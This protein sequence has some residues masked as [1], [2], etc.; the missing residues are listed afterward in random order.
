MFERR[1]RAA[2]ILMVLAALPLRQLASADKGEAAE[3]AT[4][5]VTGVT[6]PGAA[7]GTGE[8]DRLTGL[9]EDFDVVEID[10]IAIARDPWSVVSMA[11]G[12]V[13][14]RINVGGNEAGR[15]PQLTVRGDVAGRNTM[16]SIDGMTVTDMF[17]TGSSPAFW[18]IEAFSEIQV[19]T[20]GNDSSL[21]T[22]GMAI[23]LVTKRG[24]NTPRGS[25][26]FSTTSE[27]L[28][29][30]NTKKMASP[31]NPGGETTLDGFKWDPV[32]KL[33][34][35][36]GLRDYGIE[37]G[38]PIMKDRAWYWGAAGTQDI[39][40][41]FARNTQI[42]YPSPY[43]PQQRVQIDNLGLKMEATPTKDT[44]IAYLYMRSEK[45][46]R[47][48]GSRTWVRP[49]ETTWNESGP[50]NIHKADV[51]WTLG[52]NLFFEG[53]FGYV[54][55]GFHQAPVGGL[56]VQVRRDESAVYHG[57]FLDYRTQRPQWHV[58]TD[59]TYITNWWGGNHDLRFGFSFRRAD[60]ESISRWPGDR[61]IANA[62]YGIAQLTRDSHNHTRNDY[63]S[64][65]AEDVFTRGNLSISAG[66]RFDHQS[67]GLLP[68]TTPANPMRPD[69][70]PSVTVAAMDAPFS[71][72]DI[73]P[74]LGVTYD[75]SG[76]G[77]TLV[78]AGFSRYA[79]Q[80]DA[81][82]L[83]PL[84]PISEG[85]DELDY[86]WTD[87]NGDGQAQYEEI[88]FDYE[89]YE[90]YY[91]YPNDPPMTVLD[92]DL[93]APRRTEVIVGGEHEIAEG[94]VVGA[95]F[96]WRKANNLIWEVGTDYR[97]PDRLYTYDDYELAGSITG[98]LPDGTT[99][100]VPYYA[101]KPSRAYLLGAG[102]D[103]LV[104]NRHGYEEIYKGLDLRVTRRLHGDRLFLN[105]SVT[106]QK[107]RRYFNGT[108]GISNPTN[109]I[110][111]DNVAFQSTAV[112][113]IDYWVGT[114]RWQVGLSGYGR[115]PWGLS[116]G[117]NLSAREGFPIVY[118]EPKYYLDP[119]TYAT[120]VRATPMGEIVLPSAVNLDLRFSKFISLGGKGQINLDLDVFNVLNSNTPLHVHERVKRTNTNEVTDLMD[121]RL[122]RLGVRYSF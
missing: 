42:P 111:G 10:E 113:T 108:A 121:P 76:N 13:L 49:V 27:G 88:D 87:L 25:A 50:V 72:N 44:S 30:S 24:G 96:I 107:N 35:L 99:Y 51:T 3:V 82:I 100:D 37:I 97:R 57:S 48:S 52:P 89:V 80:L 106:L 63:V 58:K 65:H 41:E 105:A 68:A 84:S 15:Q 83:L 21:A 59:T 1:S 120:N 23:N 55:A 5:N 61:V 115:L 16:W 66:F 94:L 74:R 6:V 33:E 31:E 85:T 92:Q 11:H 64:F 2:L 73:S 20:G 45:A 77:K 86:L 103:S 67:G 70:L 104:T 14:D 22:G 47:G 36:T 93:R 122:V 110:D 39:R 62:Y 75:V 118:F 79:D 19:T 81:R 7:E 60:V 18:D 40:R 8:S 102:L 54:D 91:V 4:E 12:P 78:R 34:R 95:N 56:D 28:Q 9:R 53:T 112:G 101:L 32:L 29:W 116:L 26:R 90:I 109:E 69:L 114:P 117:A 46:E 119:G 17:T 38:G 71:W 98:I 43:Q